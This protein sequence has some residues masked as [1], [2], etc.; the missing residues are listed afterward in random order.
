M[1][2]HGFERVE[3]KDLAAKMARKL[4]APVTPTTRLEVSKALRQIAFVDDAYNLRVWL[5]DAEKDAWEHDLALMRA[6]D[7]LTHIRIELLA[8]DNT[9][10]FDFQ[11][12]LDADETD[13]GE[14]LVDSA[15]GVE[16]PILDTSLIATHRVVISHNARRGSYGHRLKRRWTKAAAVTK[17]PG[18]TYDS[19]HAR[20]ITGSRQS[21]V[22]H[23]SDESRK[24]LVV[25]RTGGRGYAF[26]RDD[27]TGV[28]GV[29]LLE[30]F[31]PKGTE[32]REGQRY[33]AVLVQTSR[34]I[35]ARAILP[36]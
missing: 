20:A 21:A 7:D 8:A 6:H 12:T 14:A 2:F 36:A 4:A 23:V 28:D 22:F 27:D 29:F 10:L 1:L 15:Q 11:I 9:V 5:T 34:G 30:K 33:T 19:E 35:Q 16:L 13:D 17:R 3:M 32:F 25:V 24:R 31:A 26:G 18:V